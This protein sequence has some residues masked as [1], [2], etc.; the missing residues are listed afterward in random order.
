MMKLC[1]EHTG[2]VEIKFVVY[3]SQDKLIT[4]QFY[5]YLCLFTNYVVILITL[6]M[7]FRSVWN[8]SVSFDIV[9]HEVCGRAGNFR[10]VDWG[11]EW[12]R[13]AEHDSKTFRLN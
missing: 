1:F 6:M 10:G 12:G 3:V 13:R 7:K 2:W 9:R 8:L 11:W 5:D 4:L